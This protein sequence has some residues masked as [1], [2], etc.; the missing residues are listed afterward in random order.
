[1][2]SLT[3]GTDGMTIND[4]KMLSTDEVIE[5]V[6]TMFG[7]YEPQ[8]VRRVFIPKPNGD[9]RPLGIPDHMGTDYFSNVYC[10]YWNQ[11][12]KRNFITI[13]TVFALTEV[14][15]HALARMKSLV[16]RKGNGFHYCVD[17]DIKGFFDNVHHGKLLK[18]LWTIGIRDKKLLSIISRLLK[19]EIVNEGVP[20]K[21]TP[22]G[23]ILSPLLSNIVLNELD[24]WVSNQWETIKTSHP[25]KGNSEKYRALKKS[26]LKECFLIRYAD[27]AKILCRDYVTAL[28]MFEATKD[29]L[30]TRLH[31]DISLEKIKDYKFEEKSESLFRLYS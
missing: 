15:N 8:S 13:V 24:W 22:Q 17:I 12:A 4:I 10:K 2:G 16:N 14:H 9:R 3:A 19:A 25:Y 1:M 30:R 18:Q 11:Y 29:F 6:R 7:W 27:D 23:G 20:Q 28:K 26:K 5:K 21:G 31:L